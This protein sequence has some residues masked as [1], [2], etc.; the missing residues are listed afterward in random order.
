MGFFG[1]CKGDPL[2]AELQRTFSANIL[3]VP[4]GRVQPLCAVATRRRK[5]RFWGE[6][7][8]ILEGGASI[9]IPPWARAKRPMADLNRKRSSEVD[10]RVGLSLLD[11]FLGGFLAG[12][13]GIPTGSIHAGLSSAAAVTFSFEDIERDAVDSAWL[14]RALSAR[15][16]DRK[17]G[18]LFVR[19]PRWQLLVIDS[20]ITSP[21]FSLTATK[22]V[23]G[24]ADFD[25][26]VIQAA[27]ATAHMGVTAKK[28]GERSVTFR[29]PRPL[30]FAFTL[31]QVHLEDNGGISTVAPDAKSRVMATAPDEGVLHAGPSWIELSRAPAMIEFDDDDDDDDG[32]DS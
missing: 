23:D 30:P 12:A 11:G 1:L 13:A 21:S 22:S 3:R 18:A 24:S 27:L 6:L 26:D 29:G 4:E 16:V 19:K 14:S 5:I 2:V 25:V 17:A 8:P 15:A 28:A 10:A 32:G 20:V 7:A 9:D 31:V